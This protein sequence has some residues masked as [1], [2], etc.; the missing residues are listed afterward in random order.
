M[1]DAKGILAIGELNEDGSLGSITG[2]VLAVARRLA[3]DMGAPVTAVLLGKGAAQR[4]QEAI[5]LGADRVLV[6]EAAVLQEYQMDTY[7]AA[8]E[9][10]CKAANPQVVV[11]AKTLI[12]RDVAPL[13]AF[14]LGVPMMQDCIDVSV[15]SASHR[16]IATRPVYGGNAH[17]KVSSPADPQFVCIR[18]KSFEALAP[19]SSHRGEVVQA[20]VSVDASVAKVKRVR[21][22]KEEATGVKLEDARIVVSVGRGIGGPENLPLFQELAKTLGAALG[23]SRPVCDAG[24][25]D[26][27]FQVG[28]TG[29]TIAPEL[30]ITWAISG[31]SQHIAGCSASKNIVAINR[32]PN[33][34][35]FK[36]AKY[37]VVGD[38]KK[39]L[40]GFVAAVKELVGS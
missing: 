3:K 35:I 14:R 39:V 9:Q 4:A 24:W 31:A 18:P 27:S 10:V 16:V 13:L 22:V 40:P 30:Y 7:I 19:D 25:L 33:A 32:D 28:L 29:K 34:N 5:A 2:E 15:D 20:Q 17:A 1:P 26:H 12:G 6:S 21:V 36:E 23:A 8:L 11:A 38:W 37:G